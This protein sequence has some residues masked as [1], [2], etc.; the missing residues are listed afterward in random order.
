MI[1]ADKVFHTKEISSQINS[2]RLS[3]GEPEYME[4]LES[5]VTGNFALIRYVERVPVRVVPY[6][7]EFIKIIHL[8]MLL[9]VFRQRFELVQ[10]CDQI[11]VI[12]VAFRHLFNDFFVVVSRD[13]CQFVRI[14]PVIQH[15]QR[16]V[17]SHGP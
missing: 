4:K 16:R 15:P 6:S 17:I 12:D 5:V 14:E 2:A 13:N 7:I 10:P 8:H 1:P 11:D 3:F 9:G